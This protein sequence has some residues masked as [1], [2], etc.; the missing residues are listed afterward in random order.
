MLFIIYIIYRR[1]W[2]RLSTRDV[3]NFSLQS[4]Y[5]Y[6]IPVTGTGRP[7][8]ARYQIVNCRGV[9][10]RAGVRIFQVLSFPGFA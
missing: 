9:P 3:M 10:V 4:S 1:G 2:V 6:L 8:G 7:R 5:L